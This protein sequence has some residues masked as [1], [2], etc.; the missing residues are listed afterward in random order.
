MD[1]GYEVASFPG[2]NGET[3]LFSLRSLTRKRRR[4]VA[5]ELVCV[6]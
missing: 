3:G 2:I 4:K 5:R 6:H 1:L